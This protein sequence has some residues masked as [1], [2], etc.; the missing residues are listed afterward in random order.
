MGKIDEKRML[1]LGRFLC[2]SRDIG[3]PSALAGL[4]RYMETGYFK[5]QLSGPDSYYLDFGERGVS[6]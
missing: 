3:L 6:L 4:E 5:E 1:P 2:I